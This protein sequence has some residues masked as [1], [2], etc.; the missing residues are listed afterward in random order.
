MK[1]TIFGA[2][3]RA[4]RH[5][6][7]QALDAG[8]E[9][10]AFARDP[11]R[12]LIRHE[13]LHSVQG[14]V[15]DAARV[16]EAVAGS[17]AVLSVLGQTRPPTPHLLSRAVDNIVSA[18]TRRSVR[19]LVYVTGAGVRDSRDAPPALAARV[20]VTLLKL[21]ASDVLADSEQAARTILASD[22]DWTVVR[23]PRLGDGPRTG[24]YRTGYAR[25]GFK[26]IARADLADF[27]LK[28]LTDDTYLHQSP[29]ISY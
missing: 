22:L 2:T 29:V 6:V 25:P 8:Y 12:L 28:Q 1:V 18:M 27:I 5:L 4:G 20:M 3:G 26:P 7:Q 21:A 24:Q 15:L 11:A 16:E 14:D 10:I 19:R 13:R 9:V 23:A 17:A